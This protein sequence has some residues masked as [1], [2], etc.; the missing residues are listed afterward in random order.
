VRLPF[1][2]PAPH[3]SGFK[4]AAE[5]EAGPADVPLEF[6]AIEQRLADLKK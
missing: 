2:V 5:L 3:G 4:Q 6:K 1:G